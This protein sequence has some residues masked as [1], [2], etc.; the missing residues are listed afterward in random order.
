[1]FGLVTYILV[2]PL[3]TFGIVILLGKRLPRGGDWL[4]LFS[5]W[6][7]L[8]ASLYLFFRYMLGSYDPD[9]L[10]SYS[11]NWL[12]WGNYD[13]TIGYAIDNMGIMMLV[14]VTLISALVHLYSVGYMHGDPK[15]SRFFAFLSL[16]SFSMLGLVLV[17]NLLMIY[18]F[19]ELVGLSSYLLIGFWHEKDSAANAGKKA[20]I[21]NRIG[22]AGMLIG[23]LL[24]FTTLGTLNLHEIAA[25]VTAGKLSGG[26]LTAAG[27]LLFCGAIG[28]SAQFP[29]HVWLPD[30]MEGPTPV[31][32]LIHAATMVAAG[33]YLVARLFVILTLDASLVIAYIGGFTALFAATIA[34]A[35]NDV[36]RVLAY[37]TLSQLGYMVMALGAGAYMAGFFHLV[38][39]AMF[40][41]CLF[42]GSG[43]IIHAMHHALHHIHSDADAQDM[44]NMGGL[45]KLMPLTFWTFLIATI[46]LSGV[47]LTS[48]FLSKDAILGGSL[49]FAMM[50]PKHWILPVL[51]FS[52]A[53]LTAF[54]MFR[55]IYLTFFGTFRPGEKA[56]A[57]V[58]ESPWTMTL[59]LV[60][61]ASLSISIFFVAPGVNPFNAGNGWFATLFPN[62]PRAY[63]LVLPHNEEAIEPIKEIEIVE[64]VEHTEPVAEV[65]GESATETSVEHSEEIHHENEP[66]A[67][68]HNGTLTEEKLAEEEH[69]EEAT[70]T[71]AHAAGATAHAV[72]HDA[73][74]DV[75]H[76]AHNIA[77]IISI[78]LAFSG[79]LIATAG[80]YWKKKALDPAVWQKRL[81][82]IYKGMFNKWWSDE[83]YRATAINGTIGLAKVLGWFDLYIIDG[84]VNGAAWLGRVYAMIEGWF[85]NHIIDGLV[86]LTAWIVGIFGRIVRLFQA[87][88]LQRY[89]WYT[90]V[91]IGLFILMKVV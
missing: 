46:S 39:H 58:H 72:E 62:P 61:L 50:H 43:S 23:I 21:T 52:A 16:F 76:K 33:V 18:C 11:F 6:T 20:F 44:R 25:G 32:A 87:G 3:V 86:N 79:I 22:D 66:L 78:I 4:T 82:I 36:K 19:W 10:V 15:Y 65:I 71:T 84:I 60:V 31:S 34:V 63:E 81:G 57:E 14:V 24:T 51:G 68:V 41:A 35:Q 12:K 2:A 8:F 53:I 59:P 38:T 28:K 5:I 13:L 80:Y 73:H 67:I 56:E 85:D 40:K 7:G 45:R 30:A 26:L 69:K 88:Q 27:V 9:Y 55:L 42:L 1:M 48:G 90:L 74:H 89:V 17:D 49:A 47:P 77:M 54:Y 29:L 64:H 83:I 91:F 75:H 37:S 70:H